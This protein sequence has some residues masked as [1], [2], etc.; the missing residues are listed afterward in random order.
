MHSVLI[1]HTFIFLFTIYTNIKLFNK[2]IKS[3]LDFCLILV[4]AFS[5]G[6]ITKITYEHFPSFSYLAPLLMLWIVTSLFT[7]RPQFSFIVTSIS[8]GI[9]YCL[10]ALSGFIGALIL[11]LLPCSQINFLVNS[12]LSA[13]LL[14]NNIPLSDSHFIHPFISQRTFELFLLFV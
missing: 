9:N 10:Q 1:K 5:L 12:I 13:F 8:F 14:P 3:F 2:S 7:L 4:L 6:I 11:Y